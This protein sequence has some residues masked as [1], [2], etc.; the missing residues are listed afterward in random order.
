MVGRRGG[1]ETQTTF[2]LSHNLYLFQEKSTLE[3]LD[4]LSE[5]WGGSNWES[6]REE[7]DYKVGKMI[8]G[9]FYG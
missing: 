9:D 4:K 8:I 1:V 6:C 2:L 7:S 3:S 5:V